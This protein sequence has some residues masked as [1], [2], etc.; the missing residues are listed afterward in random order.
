M[1]SALTGR[2]RVSFVVFGGMVALQSSQTF[3]VTKLI[4][5]V[6]TTL[7]LAGSLH[8]TWAA[9]TR[10]GP[11]LARVLRSWLFAVGLISAL[12]LL[13]FFVARGQGTATIDWLRDI[14]AYGLFAAVPLFALDLQSS[15]SR[16]FVIA[17]L[18]LA[19]LRGG[20]SWAV[21]GLDRRHI[22]ELPLN[23]LLFPSAQLPGMLY[24]FAMAS[25]FTDRRRGIRWALLAG[26]VLGLFLLT[27]TRSSLLLLAGPLVMA[28]VL[29]RPRL[30]SSV[31]A[32]LVQAAAALAV[33]LVVQ[34][35]LVAPTWL[36]SIG[37]GG[38]PVPGASGAGPSPT[39]PPD[40]LSG[41]FESVGSVVSDPASDASIKER[42]AQYEATWR[43]FTQNPL[44]GAGPG[45]AIEWTDVSGIARHEF[46]ADTPL[47]YLAKFGLLGLLALVPVVWAYLRTLLAAFRWTGRSAVALA[48]L[49]YGVT[50]L[51]GLPLGFAIEDKGTSLALILLLALAF[52]DV[53]RASAGATVP[54]ST[55][56][57][58]P[59]VVS[60]AGA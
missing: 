20:L 6:G 21:E 60:P 16:Q 32:L 24:V 14:A 40:V 41:R 48:L 57:R 2:A 35:V 54:E 44:L 58:T 11:P 45:H 9:R 7:C 46:T 59:G 34:A 1:A 3:D 47:V 13:S 51:V 18:V 27:G 26:F 31:R 15:S 22:L 8:A 56:E 36:A 38:A 19:G 52:G 37:S 55:T 42:V 28:L 5:L 12:I 49:G 10:I 39:A 23:R 25:A 4:Y 29:G 43:L 53:A 50:I 30:G 33:L 17:L